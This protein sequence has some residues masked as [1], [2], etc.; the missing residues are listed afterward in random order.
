MQK[1]TFD[2]FH[3]LLPRVTI[4]FS[5]VQGT[6]AHTGDRTEVS[7]TFY[8]AQLSERQLKSVVS[9]RH[10]GYYGY[11]PYNLYGAFKHLQLTQ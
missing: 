10:I 4:C 6:V 3:F 8:Y 9:W 2:E 7:N 1:V 5:F 11:Q